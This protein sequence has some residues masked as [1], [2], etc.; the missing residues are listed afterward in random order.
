MTTAAK[1]IHAGSLQGLV[2]TTDGWMAVVAGFTS[3]P[4]DPVISR[5][6]QISQL[7]PNQRR[8]AERW[9]KVLG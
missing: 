4:N 2:R 7:K 5:L 3:G 6:L 1:K 8:K 9:L